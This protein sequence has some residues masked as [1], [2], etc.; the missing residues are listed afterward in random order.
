M[1]PT[2]KLQKQPP[3]VFYKIADLKNFATFAE[4]LPMLEYFFNKVAGQHLF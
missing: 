1:L 3:E 2:L 4:K